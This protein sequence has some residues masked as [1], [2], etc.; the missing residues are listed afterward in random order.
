MKKVY[1]FFMLFF[2][3]LFVTAQNVGIGTTNPQAT[4]HV[5]GNQRIG[6]TSNYMNYDSLSGKIEWKNS[7]LYVPVSQFLVKHS[8]AG[9]G[10]YYN[11][12]NGTT[13]QLEYRNQFGNPV[14]FTNF[15]N[16][17]GYF[18]A[19]LG[20]NNLTPQF[21]LSFN[22]SVGDKISLWTDGTPTHYGFGIQS[23]LFQIFSKSYFD[24]IAFG[25][26]NSNAFTENMRVKGNG[27]VGI[28][29]TNPQFPLDINGRIRLS[30]TNPYDPGMWLNDAGA[31]RAFIGLQ[32]N[33]QVGFYGNGGIGW[34]LTMNTSNG[35][36]SFN[37]NAGTSGQVLQSNGVSTS[38]TWV[39][40]AALTQVIT[41]SVIPV[42]LTSTSDYS[43]FQIPF[44]VYVN[45][46]VT[47]SVSVGVSTINYVGCP[48]GGFAI[49][50]FGAPL[51][52]FAT[53]CGGVNET[54]TT[55]EMPVSSSVGVERV[56]TPGNS[57]VQIGFTRTPGAG[58]N[59]SITGNPGW[60][61]LKIIPL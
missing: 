10:L 58:P 12:S 60:C 19:N 57:Y 35:A 24:D 28:G 2:I 55:G 42:T 40:P 22:G 1:C 53:R 7:N 25:Y 3:S 30:G 34:G 41:K 8:A 16:G 36:V 29:N 56:Y 9:D 23:G 61:V 26:G 50:V 18:G 37:G 44:S 43:S 14:F 6:G 47:V 20:I 4:L 45:S 13:G 48:G 59:I 32:N 49:D 17:N 21:P 38:P 15:T 33:N 31:E 39:N 27:N 11:N 46:I 52:N 51:G 54:Y 5:K